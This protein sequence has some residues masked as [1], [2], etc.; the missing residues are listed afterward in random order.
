M[1]PELE[2]VKIIGA[3]ARHL[4]FHDAPF[5]SVEYRNFLGIVGDNARPTIKVEKVMVRLLEE[6]DPGLVLAP[7][8]VGNPGYHRLLRPAAK[9]GS[10]GSDCSTPKIG[11][12]P[13]STIKSTALSAL[14]QS[15]VGR[16][17]SPPTT[18]KPIS[19]A[20]RRRR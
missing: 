5:R 16:A 2:A 19:A 10:A 17:P 14:R 3:R 12:T 9:K 13:S 18:S 7:L 6:L 11:L 20:P 1:R 15:P 8:G 4:G